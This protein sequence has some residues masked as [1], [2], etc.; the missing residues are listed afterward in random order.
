MGNAV[1]TDEIR[2]Y[3]WMTKLN[4]NNKDVLLFAALY[5]KTK[6]G[7]SLTMENLDYLSFWSGYSGDELIAALNRLERKGL[8]AKQTDGDGKNGYFVTIKK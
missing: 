8:I 1:N 6:N 4:S 2:V 5:A 3:Y 7:T